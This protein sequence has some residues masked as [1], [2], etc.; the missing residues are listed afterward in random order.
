M[1]LVAEHE[2]S[3]IGSDADRLQQAPHDDAGEPRHNLLLL[4]AV[5]IVTL[6]IGVLASVVIYN[7]LRQRADA[8]WRGNVESALAR[9]DD[10]F[11]DQLSAEMVPLRTMTGLFLGSESVTAEEFQRVVEGMARNGT[12][13][14]QVALAFLG[15]V[16]DSGHRLVLGAGLERFGKVAQDP[17]LWPGLA[18]AVALAA[19]QPHHILLSPEPLFNDG[20]F[21]RFALVLAL[22][23][24]ATKGLLVAPLELE[25]LRGKFVEQR[26]PGDLFLDISVR[27]AKAKDAWPV[28]RSADESPPAEAEPFRR[29]VSVA[30]SD[31]LLLWHVSHRFLGGP[32]R[33]F[34]HAVLVGGLSF[35]LM[36]AL[37]FLLAI[38][39]IR[40]ERSQT[41]MARRNAALFQRNAVELALARDSAE[42]ANR[43]K[44]EFL[45]NMSH[46]LRT[47]LNAIIGFSDM[48]RLG[49]CGQLANQRQAECI[50]HIAESGAHLQHLISDLLDTARIESGKIELNEEPLDATAIARDAAAFLQPEA[51]KKGIRIELDMDGHPPV[52]QADRRAALQILS[53]LLGNAV[54][55]SPPRSA[56]ALRL[57]RLENDGLGI[58]IKD[59]GPGID[60]AS[61]ARI[62]ERFARGDPMVSRETDGLG[63]GLWIVKSLVE[64]HRGR[65]S[66]DSAPGQGT[67]IRLAFPPPSI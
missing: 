65:I 19:A 31:W 57:H 14:R 22:D 56:V 52:W 6:V 66:I 29:T 21:D 28:P 40:R 44:S 41:L 18:A 24:G 59:Q 15:Q 45:A 48:V 25:R 8:D 38:Y 54:K 46:E 64:M 12:A 49:L 50:Q 47:P 33:S 26:V 37:L 35:S 61:Q 63:L 16:P 62:F 43:A 17:A 23:Q 42:Q 67:T 11:A 58:E 13:N 9:L 2:T 1:S 27:P 32:D 60:A 4:V 20:K 53:N 5:P 7:E 3:R 34:P 36:G 10:S 55:F 39:E 30:D 51:A